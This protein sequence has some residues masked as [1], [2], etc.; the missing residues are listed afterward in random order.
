[1][2]KPVRPL[3]ILVG[4][5]LAALGLLAVVELSAPASAQVGRPRGTFTAASG[6]IPGTETHVVYIV[7]EVTQEMIAVQWDPRSKQLQGLGYR[8]LSSDSAEAG[9]PRGN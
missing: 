9:R 5:N 1:M 7:D 2:R 4:A 8:S 6:R 3:P